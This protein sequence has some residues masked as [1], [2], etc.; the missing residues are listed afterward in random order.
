MY[1]YYFYYFILSFVFYAII[2]TFFNAIFTS[3]YVRHLNSLEKWKSDEV[4]HNVILIFP[5]TILTIYQNTD[6]NDL[7]FRIISPY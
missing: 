5:S 4:I 1:C 2:S 3:V 7:Y 6:T